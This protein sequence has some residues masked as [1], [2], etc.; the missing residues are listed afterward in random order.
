MTTDTTPKLAE[1]SMLVTLR[2]G[3]WSGQAVD[4]DVTEEVSENNNADLKE[5]GR[6]SKQLVNKRFFTDINRAANV[7]RRT[8]QLLSLPWDD[9]GRR[10]LAAQGHQHYTEQMRLHRLMFTAKAKEF[11]DPEKVEEYVKEARPRLGD[12]FDVEDYPSAGDLSA[13]FTWDLEIGGVPEAADFRTKLSDATV[14]AVTKDIERRSQERLERAMGNVFRRVYDVA[15]K[16]NERLRAYKV[17]DEGSK[18][19]RTIIQNVLVSNAVELA[20]LIPSLNVT[21]DPKI[22]ELAQRLKADLGEHSSEVLTTDERLRR[23]TADKAEAIMKRVQRL[24]V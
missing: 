19:K 1:R 20:D 22:D 13:K 5:A 14:K 2:L 24:M 12:M 10:I 11:C 23:K 9:G 15:A 3:I 7:A 16:M 17:A 6:Y 4:R 8:H 18:E 21:G